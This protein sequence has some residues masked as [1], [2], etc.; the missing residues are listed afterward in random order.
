[1]DDR[2]AK[3]KRGK[4]DP[5]PPPQPENNALLMHRQY[6]KAEHR[7]CSSLSSGK[8]KPMFEDNA[9]HT[10]GEAFEMKVRKKQDNNQYDGGQQQA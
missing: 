4:Q 3:P 8:A 1:M 5:P 7:D 9:L 10:G 6:H 2:Q